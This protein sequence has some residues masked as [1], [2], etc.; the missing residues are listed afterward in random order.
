MA[1]ICV[2]VAQAHPAGVPAQNLENKVYLPYTENQ[3][4]PFAG[5]QIVNAPYFQISDI[6]KSK[7]TEM[8]IFWFGEVSSGTNYTDVRVGYNDQALWVYT[9]TIDRRIW[10]NPSSTGSSL[11]N[12]DTVTLLLDLDGT[13]QATRP[14]AQSYRFVT[15]FR[16]W[17]A[18]AN[19]QRVY[20]GNSEGWV[21]QPIAFTNAAR[22][23]G[24]AP[25]D[26]ADDK[27]WAMTFKIPFTSLGLSGK[28]VAGTVWRMA[29]QVYDRDSQTGSMQATQRW[30]GEN[31]ENNPSSWGRIRFGLPAY[32]PPTLRNVQ[33]TTIRHKLN[34]AVV[35]DVAAGG[36]FSC[37][38]GLDYWKEWGEE[39]YAGQDKFNIQNQE[40]ISDYPCFSK[41]F[42]TFPLTMIP[43]GKVIRSAKL[44]L[45]EFG[46]SNPSAAKP[47]L[48]QALRVTQDWSESTLNWNNAPQALENFA[49]TWVQVYPNPQHPDWPGAPYEWDVS[50]AVAQAYQQGTPMRLALYSADQPMHSGKYFVSSDTGDWN[51]TGRPTLIVEWG[52]P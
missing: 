7:F 22:W 25:N 46:G 52:D 16:W 32:T 50:L 28:P 3:Y 24:N 33:T 39:N 44:V 13:T 20:Q 4:N 51:V 29:L 11:E 12:W 47:S 41:Y 38:S 21:T 9:A 42:V 48:I 1:I 40:D 23:R 43:S 31:S 27:G 49:R 19:Y 2:L 45:H 35:P 34:G 15:Q 37:G 5:Q 17:E 18:S 6:V 36:G 10:Y 26:N 8:S 30:P 14:G